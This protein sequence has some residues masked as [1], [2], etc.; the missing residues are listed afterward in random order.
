MQIYYSSVAE[1]EQQT[2]QLDHL[3]CPHC[4]QTNQLVSH[5]YIY[6]K[7][8]G[9]EPLAV[10]KRVFCS[11]RGRHLGCGHT[12]QLYLD[13]TLRYLH[14]AGSCV[15]AFLLSLIAGQSIQRAYQDAVGTSTPRN[16]YRWLDRLTGQLTVYRSLLHQPPLQETPTPQPQ[17]SQSAY[18][19]RRAPLL[20]TV[21]M[22]L[23]RLGQPLCAAYQAQTQCAFL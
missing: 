6:K 19:T 18:P 14:V 23:Q 5:G 12:V 13:S 21:K 17:P 4:Q 1:I 16:V 3:P 2:T 9:G 11:D 10:G 22:L 8:V 20:T 15:I 7:Q